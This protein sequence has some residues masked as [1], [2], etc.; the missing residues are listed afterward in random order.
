MIAHNSLLLHFR[1]GRFTVFFCTSHTICARVLCVVLT[2]RFLPCQKSPF[3]RKHQ[4]KLTKAENILKGNL[5]YFQL[6]KIL[7]HTI[8]KFWRYK[9]KSAS[10]IFHQSLPIGMM[11]YELWSLKLSIDFALSHFCSS[12]I[13]YATKQNV[14]DTISIGFG[15]NRHFSA[16]ILSIY[17]EIFRV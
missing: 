9:L 2:A 3:S 15:S 6:Y 10:Y 8:G 11:F 4:Y 14:G 16:L 17:P 5:V 13:V 7:P 12:D 1:H